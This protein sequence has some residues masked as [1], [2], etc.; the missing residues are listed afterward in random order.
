MSCRLLPSGRLRL[1]VGP[2]AG[3]AYRECMEITLQYFDGCPNWTIAAERLAILAAERPGVT[4]NRR[5]VENVE[6]AEQI[7]FRGSPSMLVGGSDLFPD[8]SA[9]VGLACR[10]YATP[11]G[12]AGA[13]TLEQLRAAIAGA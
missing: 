6:D 3:A 8:P 1:M 9:A 4:V 7:G 2:S 5:L 10:I 11:T 13:P 12:F